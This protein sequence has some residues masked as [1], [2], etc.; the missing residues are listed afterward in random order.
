MLLW[1]AAYCVRYEKRDTYDS[2]C[3]T[4]FAVIAGYGTTAPEC[5]T[6]ALAVTAQIRTSTTQLV[7]HIKIY[8]LAQ[9]YHKRHH[10]LI[11]VHILHI[12]NVLK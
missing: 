5:G 8:I 3:T 6:A 1:G 7:T 11:Y 2:L 9:L 12:Y 4:C 10:R